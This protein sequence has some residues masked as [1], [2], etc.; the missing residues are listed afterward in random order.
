MERYFIFRYAFPNILRHGAFDHGPTLKGENR[1]GVTVQLH[2][3]CGSHVFQDRLTYC[4]PLNNSDRGA[5]AARLKVDR[6]A[7]SSLR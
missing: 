5:A 1:G 2:G 6:G 4:A 3:L 7:H